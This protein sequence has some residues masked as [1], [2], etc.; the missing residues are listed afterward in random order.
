MLIFRLIV[1]VSKATDVA[2]RGLDVPE[3]DLVIQGNGSELIQWNLPM[4]ARLS[5]TF[6]VCPDYLRCTLIC[7]ELIHTVIVRSGTGLI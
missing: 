7:D 6:T 1:I 2:A 3:L 5:G 4:R